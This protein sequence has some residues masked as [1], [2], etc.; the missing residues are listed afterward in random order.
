MSIVKRKNRL[1]YGLTLTILIFGLAILLFLERRVVK[2]R[3]ASI[4]NAV[5]LLGKE[6]VLKASDDIRISF[7]EIERLS[8]SIRKNPF[9]ND[10][11]VSKI[12]PDGTEIVVF[13]FYFNSIPKKNRPDT[14]NFEKKKLVDNGR[15]LGFLYIDLNNRIITGVRTATVSFA[16][17]L[18][19]T[20]A[21]YY[22]RVHEQEEVIS[23]TT[24]KLE[25]KGK[26]LIQLERLALAG[27]LS[28]NILHDIKKPVLN[29]RQEAA[30]LLELF[31]SEESIRAAGNIREQVDLFFNILHELGLEKFVKAREVSEEYVDIN[32][33]I[34]RSCSLVRYEKGGIRVIKNFEQKIPLLFAHPYKLI[35]LFSNLILNAYQAMNSKG[36]LDI[37]TSSGKNEIYIEI[38]DTGKGISSLNIPHL[39]T[40][41]F[42][43][44]DKK[45]GGEE[46]TGL[47]LY[48]SKNI[49]DELE[50]KIEV[51]S[52]PGKGTTFIIKIPASKDN[53]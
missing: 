10:L 46:G 15:H 52:T 39:F 38:S 45:T 1:L 22:F 4:D 23:A 13:P 26:E 30:D 49:I 8:K 31:D 36:T 32:E 25:E 37:K 6:H 53:N 51:K 18:I 11:I 33:I 5:D 40:P 3:E 9:I 34:N 41:F 19:L 35:Q 50:G 24:I 29:I 17:F 7:S 2:D 42:T 14:E 44:R 27:Q 48:I 28:A 16:L 43:T 20:L 47:G 12:L 21:S